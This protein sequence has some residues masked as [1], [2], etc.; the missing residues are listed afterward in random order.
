M[1]FVAAITTV[2]TMLP[3]DGSI[4][5]AL[6]VILDGRRFLDRRIYFA[7]P[8]DE[9]WH[10]SWAR[11]IQHSQATNAAGTHRV[12]KPFAQRQRF[13]GNF[14]VVLA[15]E[16]HM[17]LRPVGAFSET[18][19]A[20]LFVFEG[21]GDKQLGFI[22]DPFEKS[23]IDSRTI[24]FSQLSEMAGQEGGILRNGMPLAQVM[25]VNSEEGTI[26]LTLDRDIM[27][28]SDGR[29]G[30]TGGN[31]TSRELSLL[32]G[33]PIYTIKMALE[34]A[35]DAALAASYIIDRELEAARGTPQAEELQALSD[36]A[37]LTYKY[38][39]GAVR[40]HLNQQ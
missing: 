17:I 36:E 22:A 27:A 5:E 11:L 33:R 35:A 21:D 37:F 40:R 34:H 1:D 3:H 10:K 12:I 25:V 19:L 24:P 20:M 7:I 26:T 23:V 18:G 14:T 38:A 4:K 29:K 8:P 9:I 13:D 6:E 28:V 32:S 30:N 2:L 31:M 39:M 15:P 16:E